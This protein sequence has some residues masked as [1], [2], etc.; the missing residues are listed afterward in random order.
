MPSEPTVTQ[1]RLQ[2]ITTCFTGAVETLGALARSFDTPFLIAIS[3][4]S[5]ALLI[6]IQTVRQNRSSCTRLMEQTYELL[7]GIILLHLKSDTGPELSPA[8]LNQLGKFTETLHKIHVFV[9]AQ[10]DKSKIN[11][12]FRQGEMNTLLKSCDAG[13]AEAMGVFKVQEASLFK[14]VP[15]MQK[16]AQDRHQ[17]VLNLIDAAS[18]GAASD[19]ASS[20]NRVYV[21]GPSNS[22]ASISMLPSEPKIFHG[23]ESELSEVLNHFAQNAPRIAILGTGG[24]G[25][26]SIARAIL[27][28]PQITA[29]YNAQ[30]FFV[31]CDS[32]LT[33][34]ELAALLEA[35]LGLKPGRDLTRAV[36]EYFS[37]SPT[38]LLVIDNLETLWEPMETRADIED[39]LSLLTDVENLALIITMRGAE[40]PSKVRWTRPF[41]ASL[42]P[43]SQDAARQTFSDIADEG[44]DIQD[45][46]RVLQ[47]TDNM[48]LAIDLL[49][50]L[51]DIEGCSSVLS[52]WAD[53][54]TTV[55]SEGYAI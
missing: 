29:R 5:A 40:R 34:V 31:A 21:G 10:Q 33:K 39:F 12:F 22:S 42:E 19:R 38:C 51:V 49:A 2:N 8:V 43:L 18:D 25:K 52:R 35:H 7:Y 1:I 3:S 32:V 45:I 4:T 13:L 16:Y 28:H 11:R 55:I 41:L 47:L 46:D 37:N 30:R 53:E 14:D 23:R 27:H 36:V 20:T 54:K 17:E 15:N 24:M 9:E 48:P 26:T 50:H 44:H 6:S